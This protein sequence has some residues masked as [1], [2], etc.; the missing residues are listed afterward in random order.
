MNP[1]QSTPKGAVW[2][3]YIVLLYVLITGQ[4]RYYAPTGVHES[5]SRYTRDTH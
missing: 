5:H 1:D 3:G 2:A 4:S